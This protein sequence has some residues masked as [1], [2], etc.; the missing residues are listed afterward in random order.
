M[1]IEL[2]V[3]S[4][5]A[6][7]EKGKTRDVAWRIAALTALGRSIRRHQGEIEKALYADPSSTK[8]SRIPIIL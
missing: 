5:R 4:Q 1:E 7:F 8:S 6:Y 2:L 3:K